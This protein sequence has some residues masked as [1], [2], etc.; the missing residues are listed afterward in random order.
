MDERGHRNTRLFSKARPHPQREVRDE[1]GGCEGMRGTREALCSQSKGEGE[2]EPG[3]P[4]GC[5]G[6]RPLPLA[7]GAGRSYCHRC[8]CDTSR[9]HR[10]WGQ[11][12]EGLSVGF[13]EPSPAA[14]TKARAGPP[15][16]TFSRATLTLRYKTQLR[17]QV[18]TGINLDRLE[19]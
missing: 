6:C 4:P 11:G 18:P 19:P 15:A 17:T 10:G 7:Q 8:V 2:R 14:V 13:P 16:P 3:Q 12:G 1:N 9:Q 5:A